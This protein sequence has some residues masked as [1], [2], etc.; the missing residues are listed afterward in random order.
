[1]AP[2]FVLPGNINKQGMK[3]TPLD[4]LIMDN[5]DT[6]LVTIVDKACGNA[7][8]Y[9]VG[10]FIKLRE[11][12]I[13]GHMAYSLDIIGPSIAVT[14]PHKDFSTVLLGYD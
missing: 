1:M 9:I 11:S 2:K 4:A 14:G 12:T 5:L 3:E 13:F 7:S 10:I 6:L 8:G